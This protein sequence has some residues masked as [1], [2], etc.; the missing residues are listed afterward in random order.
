M[1]ES[2]IKAKCAELVEWI[3]ECIDDERDD[4]TVIEHLRAVLVAI[5]DG[6][7]IPDLEPW[8]REFFRN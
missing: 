6:E 2:E 7:E 1:S 8:M 5:R 4:R 3:D